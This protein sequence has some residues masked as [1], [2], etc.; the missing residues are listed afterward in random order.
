MGKQPPSVLQGAPQSGGGHQ[1]GMGG[2][3][4]KGLVQPLAPLPQLSREGKTPVQAS[5]QHGGGLQGKLPAAPGGQ[6][7]ARRANGAE[8]GGGDR[9]KGQAHLDQAGRPQPHLGSLSRMGDQTGK[10]MSATH[11][12]RKHPVQNR[13]T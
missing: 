6:P 10:V 11:C 9:I 1:F 8:L 13:F 3:R 7:A 2:Q 5:P 12:Q 4:G